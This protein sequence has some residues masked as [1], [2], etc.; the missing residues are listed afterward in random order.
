MVQQ[1]SFLASKHRPVSAKD[2]MV[3]INK[4]ACKRKKPT[5]G[6]LT[7]MRVVWAYGPLGWQ[8]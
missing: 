1:L 7:N 4:A 8:G 6:W 2:Q 3:K 5:G